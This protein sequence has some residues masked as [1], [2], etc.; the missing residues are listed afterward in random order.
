MVRLHSVLAHRLKPLCCVIRLF[1]GLTGPVFV[2][3]VLLQVCVNRFADM[4]GNRC[5]GFFLQLFQRLDLF[6]CQINVGAGFGVHI[7]HFTQTYIKCKK[8]FQP[9]AA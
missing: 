8:F 1:S 5:A 3:L 6:I 4:P 7:H 2:P 9:G